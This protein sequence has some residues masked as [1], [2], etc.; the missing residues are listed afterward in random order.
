MERATSNQLDA[1]RGAARKRT[2]TEHMKHMER[3]MTM[4]IDQFSRTL[5]SEVKPLVKRTDMQ[6]VKG[7]IKPLA[8]RTNLTA[9]VGEIKPL[10]TKTNLQSVMGEVKPLT[11]KANLQSVMAE[12]QPRAVKN[13]VQ[14]V[15]GELKT[16]ATGTGVQTV[17]T[18]L[19][20]VGP[21]AGLQTAASWSQMIHEILHP[22]HDS[23]ESE[24]EE[25]D[26][27]WYK[28]AWARLEERRKYMA[29]T[30]R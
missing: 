23:D 26:D 11:T 18:D 14:A 24:D 10:T 9:V 25:I 30:E 3:L 5:A 20:S 27:E 28:A 13:G 15:K 17:K 22:Q 19:H 8:T 29:G 12:V 2:L 21:N 6:A 4:Q 7:E 16:R 1:S